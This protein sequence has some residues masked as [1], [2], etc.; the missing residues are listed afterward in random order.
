MN[1]YE[2][3]YITESGDATVLKT[4]EKIISEF[5]G[6]VTHKDEWGEKNLAYR[7]GSLTKG[8]YHIW[9]LSL[10]GGQI[11]ALKNRLN[12]EDTIVRYLLIKE[13]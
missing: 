4:V 1:S 13:E 8:H 6:E 5:D 7:I 11:S 3:A 10:P 12:L 9:T 2:F